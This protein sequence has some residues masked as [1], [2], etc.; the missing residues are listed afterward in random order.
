MTGT[1]KTAEAIEKV[2]AAIEEAVGS[3]ETFEARD[4]GREIIREGWDVWAKRTQ[5]GGS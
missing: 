5:K 2:A 3:A 4:E 1:D